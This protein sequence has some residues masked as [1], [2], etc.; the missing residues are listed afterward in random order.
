[1]ATRRSKIPQE[2]RDAIPEDI[3]DCA[4]IG[5][6]KQ[7]GRYYA[8]K[9][10]GVKY[11]PVRKRGIDQRLPLGSIKDGKFT[12]SPTYLKEK[13]ISE[14][15]NELRAKDEAKKQEIK[16]TATRA[17]QSIEK[18]T[19]KVEEVRQL[20][21]VRYP[22]NDI[23]TVCLLASFAGYTSAVSIANYWKQHQSELSEIFD[24]L[25][26]E[27]PSHDTINRLLRL[28]DPKK[29]NSLL[30]LLSVPQLKKVRHIHID[31]QA[32]RASKTKNCQKG[33]YLFNAYDSA[34][35]FFITHQLIDEKSNE[36]THAKSLLESLALSSGDIFTSDAMNTQKDL[37]DFARSKKAD[38]CLAVKKNQRTL[39]KGIVEQILLHGQDAYQVSSTDCGHGRIETR[40]AS[41]LPAKVLSPNLL[42]QWKDLKKGSII[43]T[44]TL[45]EFKGGV[46]DNKDTFQTRYFITS[47]PCNSQ[48]QAEQIVKIIRDH[49]SIENCLHWVLDVDFN[50]DRLQASNPN[51][52]ANRSL[53][54]KNALNVLKLAQKSYKDNDKIHYSVKSLMQLCSNPFD[55]LETLSRAIMILENL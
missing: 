18:T 49:W 39:Y 21:K 11:D 15:K 54:I 2:I 38:Y 35:H 24:Q 47:L 16:E 6:S 50:E 23:L 3:R 17:I 41:I 46:V 25:P 1:M 42:A 31:G 52:L 19:V 27:I 26:E 36:I 4:I 8:Y 37:V 48:E 5:Y 53:L 30:S 14:L 40:S 28:I 12:Y 32:V 34:R 45:R 33:R 44:S 13:K 7:S 43:A 22:I 20:A 55:A 51:Y 10:L 29:F 9:L